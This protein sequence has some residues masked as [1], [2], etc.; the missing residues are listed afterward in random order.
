[1]I[2]KLFKWL[3]RIFGALLGLA[4]IAYVILLV[5]NWNDQ[6]PSETAQEF[7]DAIKNLPAV[8]DEDNAYFMV[9]EF[10]DS[11]LHQY[12]TGSEFAVAV[13]EDCE[14]DQLNCLDYVAVQNYGSKLWLQEQ[15]WI[16]DKYIKLIGYS[17]YLEPIP[18][19]PSHTEIMSYGD[20]GY[21]HRLLM[22]SAMLSANSGDKAH[23][24]ALLEADLNF[25]RLLLT[26]SDLLITKLV[27]AAYVRSH[28]IEGNRVL[29]ELHKKDRVHTLPTNWLIEISDEETSMRRA[30]IGEWQWATNF[31]Q[32][33]KT[34]Q[35]YFAD[36]D[37]GPVTRLLGK[38]AW[39]L[40]LPLFQLRE[41]SNNHATAFE[42][43]I[44]QLDVPH[45]DF[46]AAF[47][48]S[49]TISFAFPTG[50]DR[51]YNPVGEFYNP[52]PNLYRKYFAR[53]ADLEGIRR[54][55]VL[56]TQLREQQVPLEQIDGRL[57]TSPYTNPYN[58]EAFE[59]DP[60]SGEIVFRGLGD[61]FDGVYRF[62]Y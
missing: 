29:L 42:A 30:L 61:R 21:G 47:E 24:I 48:S 22:A 35:Y 45:H 6:P 5:I 1:M 43:V 50:I 49:K 32:T 8:A 18:E 51:L 36:P 25:L 11:N 20:V 62:R 53:T 33:S 54:A 59:W 57:A 10:S 13:A 37:D 40:M 58:D 34:N 4:I 17:K 44:K 15:R 28:F 26:E 3:F 60:E 41:S 23:A 19:E 14:R 12:P 39:Q 7:S 16:L 38:S 27:A 56:T 55:A 2:K 46:P 52:M 31:L 9:K